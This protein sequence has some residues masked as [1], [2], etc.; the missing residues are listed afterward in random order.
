MSASKVSA[1]EVRMLWKVSL[2]SDL[3]G[4]V[5]EVEL[6]EHLGIPTEQ[7]SSIVKTLIEI[8][9]YDPVTR[10]MDSSKLPQMT[11]SAPMTGEE[12]DAHLKTILG[13]DY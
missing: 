12:F 13:D 1:E 4:R 2:Q 8:G 10:R 11:W 7:A 5:D 9:F 3:L 6:S